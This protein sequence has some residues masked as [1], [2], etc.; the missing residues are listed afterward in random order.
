MFRCAA[1][2]DVA[3]TIT[4]AGLLSGCHRPQGGVLSYT[5]EPHTYYSY[6]HQPTTVTLLDTRTDEVVFA[7]DIPPGKQLSIQFIEGD[8]DDPV[9]TPDLMVYEV[10]DRGT[11]FGK[12]RNS[13]TVPSADVR[14]VDV[15]YRTGWEPRPET[16]D[17]QLTVQQEEDRPEWWTR[18]GGPVPE[19]DRPVNIY[20]D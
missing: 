3:A 11:T 20:D 14:R 12:L 13:V 2:L 5:G 4:T 8:G 1:A 19:G 17:E 18:E 7:M 6:E 9:Y 16:G 15:D 10:M